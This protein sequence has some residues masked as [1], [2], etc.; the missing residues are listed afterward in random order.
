MAG[1][2]QVNANPAGRSECR[3]MKFDHLNPFLEVCLLYRLPEFTVSPWFF[4]PFL[5]VIIRL[6]MNISFGEKDPDLKTND[7]S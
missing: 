2:V 6:R 5:I 7:E 1:R 4:P 3:R